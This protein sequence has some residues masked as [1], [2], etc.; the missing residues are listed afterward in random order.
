MRKHLLRTGVLLLVL[1]LAGTS[2]FASGSGERSGTGTTAAPA[3]NLPVIG[4]GAL[5]YDPN[6]PVN[7]GRNIT[8]GFWYCDEGPEAYQRWAAAIEDYQKIHT[9]VRIDV[10]KSLGW[11]DYWTKLPVAI[12]SGTGPELMHFHNA[13]YQV[14]IPGLLEPLPDDLAKAVLE[15]F[16]GVEP[17]M[18]NGK[19]YTIPVGDMTGTMFYNKTMWAQ[20]G[21][22]DRDIP[23]TWDELR[24]VAKKLTKT[25]ASGRNTVNGFE[26]PDGYFFLAL[27][28]QKGYNIFAEDGKHTQLNNPGG[29]EAAKM[30]Q[31][32][33]SVDKIT[34]PGSG[35]PQ[36]RFGNQQSAIMY[37]WTWIAAWLDGNVA[38]KFDWGVFPTPTFPG[39]K[40]VDRNNPEVSAVVNS[41][42][43]PDKKAAA[44]DFLKFYFASDK[45]MV[46]LG[47]QSY[48]IPTKK[49]AIQDPAILANRVNG[50]VA[51]YVGRTIW[52]GIFPSSF[53]PAMPI[54][55]DEL[56]LQSKAPA[57]TLKKFDDEI[58]R[59]IGDVIIPTAE[60]LSV[61]GKTL[62]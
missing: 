18:Y 5:K 16:N 2:V 40:V 25:D 17:W 53:D 54:L 9:N 41:S 52:T 35:T 57:L 24:T 48:V 7:N 28:Y 19:L 11:D 39:A 31:D 33:I 8:I 30:I 47:N 60:R 14:F 62:K 49:S 61:L 4:S 3:T 36:E 37:G 46:E 45:Y 58:A 21:L 59:N 42:S 43:S 6:V 32:W 29:L 27:N 38:N 1:A 13:Y 23:K 12:A 56:I 51:E 50:V 20:A 15:D 26:F 22:T 34:S 44:L 10:N 55:T